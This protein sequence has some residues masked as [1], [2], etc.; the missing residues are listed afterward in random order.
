VDVC[1]QCHGNVRHRGAAFSYRPGQPL[2]ATYRTVHSR[3][4]EDDVNGNQVQYLRASKCF[5]KSEMTC[6]TCHDPHRPQDH[7]AVRRVCLDCHAPA[8]CEERPRLP[9]AVRDDCAACHMPARFAMTVFFHTADD[10]YMP[11]APRTEHRIA[12]YPEATQTVRLAWHRT[13]NDPKDRAEADRLAAEL[14]RHWAGEAD[15]FAQASRLMAAIGAAREAMKVSPDDATRGRL[16]AAIARQSEFDSLRKRVDLRR[17][18]DAVDLLKKALA[19][20]PD[21]ATGRANLGRAYAALGKNDEAAAEFRAVATHDPN[22]A[23]GLVL[24]AWMEYAGGRFHEAVALNARAAEIDPGSV[25][26]HYQWGLALLGLEKWAEAEAHFRRCLT[27]HPRHAGAA[28]GLSAALRQQGQTAEAVRHAERAVRWT[29]GRDAEALL[30]LARAYRSA[31]RP[32]DA[33]RA[34]EDALAEAE[35]SSPRLVPA[36]RAELSGQ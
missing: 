5:Q 16:R 23:D 1:A 32:A 19:I 21:Y 13:R 6:V 36:V 34:L 14:G 26:V 11:V 17:P 10:E 2:D 8:A 33:R 30:T 27:T 3:D 35:T 29:G 24:L 12:V 7:A 28:G 22:N 9:G 18:D 15:R 25:R 4:V 20:K 31:G